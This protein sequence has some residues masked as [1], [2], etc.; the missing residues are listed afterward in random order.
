MKTV[1]FVLLASFI[2]FAQADE[3]STDAV[4]L[5]GAV[6]FGYAYNDDNSDH[7][8]DMK[9]DTFRL[10]VRGKVQ[11]VRVL[12]KWRWFQTHK[13]LIQ[14]AEM[15][16]DFSPASSLNAGLT[17][18]PFGNQEYNSH[19][20]DLSPN[21]VL[22]L[23]DNYQFGGTYVFNQDGLN[24]QA[25]FFKNDSSMAGMS[26]D[27]YSPTLNTLTYANGSVV[28]IGG[29]NMGALRVVQNFSPMDELRIELGGSALYGGVWDKTNDS[30]LGERQAY[31]LHSSI[32]WQRVHVQLQATHYDYALGAGA[33]SL[34]MA[35]YG[36]VYNQIATK[37]MSYTTNVKYSLPVSLGPIRALDFYNDYTWVT[38]KPQSAPDSSDNALGMGIAAGAVYVFLDW[39]R[40]LNM[41]DMTARTGV[42]HYFNANF[43]YYF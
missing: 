16:Y 39:H 11:G 19:N 10:D 32:Q 24:V 43:G 41:A 15:G 12:S 35:Y 7:G 3:V 5:G 29:F 33:K 36:G 38:D 22:G 8:G 1:F 2:S 18:V 37:A 17:L 26:T 31:A 13:A 28:D 20:F 42:S 23:E 14:V 34:G 30:E 4:K 27:S 9:F 21:F 25:S 40:Q 6:R